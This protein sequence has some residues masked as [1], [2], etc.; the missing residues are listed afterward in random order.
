MSANLIVANREQPIPLDVI[1]LE[2]PGE[3]NEHAHEGT[4]SR[5]CRV[6]V[7]GIRLESVL[8]G[9]RRCTSR[10]AIGR[11]YER[12]T[13]ASDAAPSGHAPSPGVPRTRRQKDK[14]VRKAVDDLIAQGA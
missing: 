5:W 7:R 11:F 3:G 8:C 6:G 12:L 14:A 1:C 13:E 9:V 2:V 4:L 10:E